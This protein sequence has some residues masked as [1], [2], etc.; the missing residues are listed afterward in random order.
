MPRRSKLISWTAAPQKTGYKNVS[1]QVKLFPHKQVQRQRQRRNRRTIH[2]EVRW[3]GLLA[4]SAV[5]LAVVQAV[6]V[7]LGALVGVIKVMCAGVVWSR[8]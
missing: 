5:H 3:G 1:T 7:A 4:N 2:R 6:P 8:D